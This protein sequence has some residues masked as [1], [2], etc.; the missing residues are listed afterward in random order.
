MK[1]KKELYRN[2]IN[3]S[4][5]KT[6]EKLVIIESDDWGGI[7]M[8][9]KEVYDTLKNDTSIR[10]E[11]CPYSKYD[12]LEVNSDY[13]NLYSLLS[14]YKD[15]SGNS[16]VITANFLTA[17]PDFNKIRENDFQEYFFEDITHTY[18]S[19]K[20]SER[21]LNLIDEGVKHKL[22]KPQLHGREHINPWSWLRILHE[23]EDVRKAFDYNICTLSF[24]NV[25]T[26]KSPYL[27]SFYRVGGED[28]TKVLTDAH[29]QFKEI[30]KEAPK[31]FI[32]PVY[33]WDD[34][35][36]K[37]TGTLGIES[38]QGLHFKYI[39]KERKKKQSRT[40]NTRTPYGQLN[41][42][43]NCFF[44]PSTK[45]DFDW[46]NECLKDI[47]TAFL[48]NR[49]AV[50]CSHRLN[51]MGRIDEKNRDVNLNLLDSL[52]AGIVKKWPD[53]KFISSDELNNKISV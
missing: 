21:V 44:E 3:S 28:F 34:E 49:P 50:I 11:R 42:V 8:P 22:F 29:T 31:S 24:E 16:P 48:W 20:D 52:L 5:L 9:S 45:K 6:K 43:R 15:N 2:Y 12:A 23:N 7:R 19:Y 35:V 51:F 30:F 4:G 53:V 18:S 14:K 10:V 17:N 38:I 36:E 27:A 1:I 40:R 39:D 26:I 37:I 47:S 33:V 25:K 46:V 32:A 13:E 41:I